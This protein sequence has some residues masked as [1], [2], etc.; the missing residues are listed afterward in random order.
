MADIMEQID[1]DGDDDVDSEHSGQR[2]AQP[3]PA[4]P[5]FEMKFPELYVYW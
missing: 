2:S 3:A 5:V 1:R 4:V